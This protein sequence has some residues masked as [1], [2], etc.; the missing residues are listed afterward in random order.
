MCKCHTY[1]IF[2]LFIQLI[3]VFY[4]VGLTG[5]DGKC[6]IELGMCEQAVNE[7]LQEYKALQAVLGYQEEAVLRVPGA[8][9]VTK[10]QKENLEWVNSKNICC[11][12]M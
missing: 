9:Q 5:R 2:K 3:C 10:G 6:V 11:D 1:I 4:C 8:S 7:I 12:N